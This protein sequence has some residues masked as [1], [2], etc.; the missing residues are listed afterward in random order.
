MFFKTRQITKK[1]LLLNTT[2][3]HDIANSVVFRLRNLFSDTV[4]H[5]DDRWSQLTCRTD[6]IHDECDFRVA[7]GSCQ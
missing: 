4:Y 2:Y 6:R 3:F 7:S 5:K 1:T